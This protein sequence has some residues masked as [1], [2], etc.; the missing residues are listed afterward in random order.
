M[1]PIVLIVGSPAAGKS[2]ASRALAALYP[3][4]IAIRVDEI[5]DMVV[6]NLASPSAE[7]SPELTEQLQLVRTSVVEMAKTYNAAGFAV[8]IDDFWD[9]FTQLNEYD[10][11]FTNSNFRRVLLYPDQEITH[12]RNLQR[13]GPGLLQ[14]YLDEGIRIVYAD[15]NRVVG[16]LERAGWNVLDTTHDSVEDTAARLYALAA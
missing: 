9:P 3:K 14:D 6:S 15:L 8:V 12:A 1:L 10:A 5:R 13:S 4:S 16:D 11:L 7:W 2:S